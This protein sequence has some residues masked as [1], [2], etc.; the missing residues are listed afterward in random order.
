MTTTKRTSTVSSD[1]DAGASP[2]RMFG[3]LLA[4]VAGSAISVQARVNGAL[5]T[6]LGDGVTAALVSF[7]VG[8]VLLLA[9]ALGLPAARRGMRRIWWAWVEH[10]LRWWHFTGGLCGALVVACQG[11]TVGIL[12]VA[13]FT[14]AVV[15]GQIGS[16]LLM[17]EIGVGPS[18]VQP[19]SPRRLVGALLAITAVG[20]AIS[21]RFAHPAGLALAALPL[22]AGIG[23]A[24]Q[25]GVNGKVGAAARDNKEHNQLTSSTLPAALTNFVTGTAALLVIAGVRMINHGPPELA[26]QWWL[27][28][29][30]PLG[31]VIIGAMVVLVRLIGMLLL[32]LGMVAGQ[33][34]ASLLLD[35]F[36]PTSSHPLNSVALVGTALTLVAAGI[37]AWP[38]QVVQD[39]SV[40]HVR[41]AGV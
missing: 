6:K 38:S 16:S 20:L 40:G 36:A 34:I 2:Q 26:P 25:Q 37:A 32:G 14:V 31:I 29:G 5:A 12:G 9:L 39:C 19:V 7:G 4:L 11:L 35:F 15:G 24:W 8:L 23:L 21:D 27:Y 30:G 33:L 18:G 3:V 10:R 13:V 1:D 17:D 41:G 22:L 28:L